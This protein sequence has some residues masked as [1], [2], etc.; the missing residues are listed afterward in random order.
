M[1]SH[2]KPT[3]RLFLVLEEALPELGVVTTAMRGLDIACVLLTREILIFHDTDSILSYVRM[4]Q[5]R[6]VA[7]GTT[8]NGASPT[9]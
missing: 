6:G 9:A 2:E 8:T 5:D 1:A 3:A 7:V 4:F